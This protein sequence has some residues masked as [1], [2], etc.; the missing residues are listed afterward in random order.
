MSPVLASPG[1]LALVICTDSC[2]PPRYGHTHYVA[3]SKAF[4]NKPEYEA[5]AAC[6]TLLCRVMPGQPCRERS[7]SCRARGSPEAQRVG[8]TCQGHTLGSSRRYCGRVC[9]RLHPPP[10]AE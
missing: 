4:Q 9:L 10:L 5:R 7:G 3:S 8:P 1:F 2:L 6:R